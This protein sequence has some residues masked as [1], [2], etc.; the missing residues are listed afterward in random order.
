MNS[1]RTIAPIIAA[2]A[3]TIL[4][5]IVNA[6]HDPNDFFA[7]EKSSLGFGVT[8][9]NTIH[10]TSTT[11]VWAGTTTD[12]FGRIFQRGTGNWA[13][14]YAMP[15]TFLGVGAIWATADNHAIA[16]SED[17][18]ANVAMKWDG[19]AW[20][21]I[22]TA[23]MAGRDIIGFT[24]L[25]Y[26]AI[27][28]T[29]DLTS[30]GVVRQFNGAS[31]ITC[32][33]CEFVDSSTG[34]AIHGVAS[35][36]I[37]ALIGLGSVTQFWHYDGSAW[38]NTDNLGARFQDIFM[39][40]ATNGFAVGTITGQDSAY[41]QYDGVNWEIVTGDTTGVKHRNAVWG[42]SGTNIWA[43]GNP[44]TGVGSKY[45]HWD[46]SN[47]NDEPTYQTNAVEILNVWCF[48]ASNCWTTGQIQIEK[49]RINANSALP[50]LAALEWDPHELIADTDN[51]CFG[52]EVSLMAI[53]QPSVGLGGLM[54]YIINQ[55]SNV[56]IET[57]VGSDFNS[58]NNKK[59]STSRVYPPGEYDFIV[60]ADVSGLIGLDNWASAPVVVRTGTCIDNSPT[61]IS[62]INTLENNITTLIEGI[63][64]LV[65]TT[66]NGT[67]LETIILATQSPIA[68]AMSAGIIFLI[69]AALII[70]AEYSREFFIYIAAILCDTII[71]VALSG[72]FIALRLIFAAVGIL[73]IL[74]AIYVK[75]NEG[76]EN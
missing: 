22:T 51:A 7:V 34:I 50:S 49:L 39:A 48:D 28:N 31:W 10:G 47:W 25:N 30:N 68:E 75:Q 17:E 43:V 64:I 65:N 35:N 4:F 6:S 72:D 59:F 41:A 40:S 13:T 27:G 19:S 29:P 46:G 56:V 11:N 24:S 16:I 38:T 14:S 36:N 2:L 12:S 70:W 69:L 45:S 67:S 60:T 21:T 53:V 76:E 58:L 73:I 63:D 33:T 57:L 55:D 62:K 37:W 44:G 1:N 5:P 52:D 32:A 9:I 42:T 23:N 15:A 61:V 66:V 20:T 74:R 71:V 26:W 3:I 18:S 54:A 8:A